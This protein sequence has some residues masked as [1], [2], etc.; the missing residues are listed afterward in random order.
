MTSTPLME[1]GQQAAQFLRLLFGEDADGYLPLWSLASKRTQ[2]VPARQLK[3]AAAYSEA[4]SA[5]TDVYFSPGLQRDDRGP[6]SRGDEAGVGF[7]F[8]HL[9]GVLHGLSPIV[10]L[11]PSVGAMEPLSNCTFRAAAAP[12]DWTDHETWTSPECSFGAKA[13][14]AMIAGHG[15]SFS[16]AA[17]GFGKLDDG[18]WTI[19]DPQA[20]HLAARAM[21]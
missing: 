6:T 13:P 8:L 14:G 18:T 5:S 11:S 10:A 1:G 16:I 4:A 12:S 3:A 20:I 15:N 17:V 19:C 21:R 2:W 7:H 9:L